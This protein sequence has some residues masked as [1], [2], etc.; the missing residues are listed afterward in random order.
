MEISRAC[1][2]MLSQVDAK[3]SQPLL[4]WWNSRFDYEV[5]VTIIKRGYQNITFGGKL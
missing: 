1:V 2:V 5:E 3:I 4:I